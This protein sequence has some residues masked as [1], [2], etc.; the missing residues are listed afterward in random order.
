MSLFGEARHAAPRPNRRATPRH[1]RAKLV[2]AFALTTLVGAGSFATTYRTL[3]LIMVPAT[4]NGSIPSGSGVTT[5]SVPNR[6][7]L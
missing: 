6:P 4:A 2:A 7:R 5:V 1:R 3:E